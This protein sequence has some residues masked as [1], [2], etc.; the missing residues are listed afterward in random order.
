MVMVADT[1]WRLL[2]P[3]RRRLDRLDRREAE[4]LL[5]EAARE[6]V[7]SFDAY[8]RDHGRNGNNNFLRSV[9]KYRQLSIDPVLAVRLKAIVNLIGRRAWDAH[10]QVIIARKLNGNYTTIQRRRM[11]VVVE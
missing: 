9:P 7:E 2:E 1:Y 3:L 5:V 8:L 4:D 6:A 11:E 10:A